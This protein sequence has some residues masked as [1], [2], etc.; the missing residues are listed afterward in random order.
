MSYRVLPQR[1][2]MLHPRASE[3]ER[4][5]L[6]WSRQALAKTRAVLDVP[7]G[8]DPWQ[9][10]DIY[11]PTDP[12]VT[13]RPVFLFLHGGAWTSGHKE[14][15][16]FLAPHFTATGTIFVSVSYRLAP[17]AR[18]PEPLW[19]TIDAFA[20]IR[21]NIESYGGDPSLL[22]VGGHSAGG[23]LATLATLQ[24]DLLRERGFLP[25]AIKACL[26]LSSPFDLCAPE[27]LRDPGQERVYRDLLARPEDAE[28]ASPV[29]HVHPVNTRFLIAYGQHDFPRIIEQSK[30]LAQLLVEVDCAVQLLEL[31]DSDHFD[32]NMNGVHADDPWVTAAQSLIQD[33]YSN[34]K[35]SE[36]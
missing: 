27:G 20:W 18:F 7:Y 24:P 28:E 36:S 29:A 32:T 12:K 26:P 34:S 8:A 11:L 17:E 10:V 33:V 9:A 22:I 23:H 21:N 13:G 15:M 3:Y 16:G 30:R 1:P 19:D 35:S 2:A 4:N 5:I 25:D 6:E 14:W 31:A